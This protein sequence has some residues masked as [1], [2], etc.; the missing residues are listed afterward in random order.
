MSRVLV[1]GDT[2]APCMLDGYVDFLKDVHK[3]WDCT[4]VVHIGDLID[5]HSISFHLK[6]V[7]TPDVLGEIEAAHEQVQQLYKAFPK[8]TVMT[9]NHDAIPS[10]R[11]AEMIMPDSML[12]PEKEY[13]E[14]PGWT[15]KPR[16]DQLVIDGVI[17]QHGDRGKGGQNAA[18]KNAQAEFRSVVQGHL[19]SQMG[20]QWFANSQVRIFA[21]QTGCGVDHKMMAM[22][23]GRKFNAKPLIGCGVVVDGKYPYTEPMPL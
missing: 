10:R 15:F 8:V 6:T 11:L 12:R 4:D 18:M 9:G 7:G 23:Y 13:W 16:Y 1:I 5:W 21:M 20:V 19:H 2:H 14:V 3:A 22:E 17:Y